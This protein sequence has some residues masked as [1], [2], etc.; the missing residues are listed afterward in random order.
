[1][2]HIHKASRISLD[3]HEILDSWLID[4]SC[5]NIQPLEKD[6]IY[7]LGQKQ[8]LSFIIWPLHLLSPKLLLLPNL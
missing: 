6:A 8:I 2:L 3:S 5:E 1:M 7:L 4:S